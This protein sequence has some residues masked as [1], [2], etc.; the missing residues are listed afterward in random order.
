MEDTWFYL[1]QEQSSRLV[2]VQTQSENGEWIRF[3]VTF[4]DPDYPIKGAKRFFSGGA[5][6]SSTARDYATFLQM[7]LNGGELNGVRILS[8]T[9]IASMMRNQIG[10]LWGEGSG[11]YYGLAFGVINEKGQAMGG[12][13]SI[14][15]FDWGGYFNTQYFADPQEEIVGILMKQTQG[16]VSD[17]TGWKFR[18]L[19]GQ[20]VDD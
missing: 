10:E 20:A 14:R 7:Y 12:Q 18:L 8:R 3:P 5:G 6:L 15:T 1:P 17:E 16:S 13:G 11:R 19:V 4:Y 9:T 2:S